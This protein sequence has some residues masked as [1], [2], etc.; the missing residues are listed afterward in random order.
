MTTAG[1]PRSMS[2][3]TLI[4]LACVICGGLL[5]WLTCPAEETFHLTPLERPSGAVET[6][7]TE[8]GTGWSA[9]KDASAAV[10][11]AVTMALAGRR[12]QHPD[13]AVLFATSG[14][15]I[16]AIVHH[17]RRLLGPDT[18]LFGGTSDSRA[19]MTDRGFVKAT[20]RGY[21]CSLMEGARALAVMTV[22]SPQITFG[23]GGAD[24]SAHPSVQEAA[25]S[26][27]SAAVRDAGRDDGERPSVVL[28]MC[29]L[30]VEEEA[31]EGIAS[32]VGADV[33]LLGGTTGG[34]TFAVIGDD[35]AYERGICVAV[36]YTTLPVGWTFE[37]GFDVTDPHA[38]VV[39]RVEKQAIVEIDGRPALD[40]Y[41]EWLGGKIAPLLQHDVA[42]A[43]RLRD[44][45]LLHPVYRKYTSGTG[46]TY[47]LFSHPWP[48]ANTP[49]DKAIMTSTKIRPG[50]RVYLSRGTWGTLMNRIGS[51]PRCAKSHAGLEA[52]ARPLFSLGFICGGV[53]GAI[54]ENEREKLPMLINYAGGRSPFIAA[55]TWGEQGHFP[56]V[57]NKHGNLLTSFLVIGREP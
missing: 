53:M 54:P 27:M 8:V 57:G 36:V 34:P 51:L 15:D 48:R 40:V 6:T 31:L 12:P 38:G 42:G 50:E 32:V 29:T 2:I 21:E 23:V 14:S 11:E 22:T 20:D 7:H 55:F 26:A 45:L 35:G 37:G 10:A 24:F 44:L 49:E 18:R 56:G 30:G 28:S 9:N 17:A 41:N 16:E 5:Y 46:R 1:Y 39:T 19:V 33:P 25:R 47:C 4:A 43:D 13:F 3:V 52:T